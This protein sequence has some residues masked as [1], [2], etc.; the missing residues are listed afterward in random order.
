LENVIHLVIA[1]DYYEVAPQDK[2]MPQPF[3]PFRSKS[4]GKMWGNLKVLRQCLSIL[5]TSLATRQLFRRLQGAKRRIFR[6]QNDFQAA[7]RHRNVAVGHPS[8]R[9]R[10]PVK[11]HFPNMEK[12]RTFWRPRHDFQ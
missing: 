2:R 4:P 7:V 11:R 1:E 9:Q 12:R 10:H 8:K 6:R 3:S 5:G